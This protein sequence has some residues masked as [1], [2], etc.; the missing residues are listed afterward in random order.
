MAIDLRRGL[1][2]LLI[3]AVCAA[4]GSEGGA[5]APPAGPAVGVIKIDPAIPMTGDTIRL[6]VTLTGDAVRAEIKWTI[7][8]TEVQT[9]ECDGCEKP[10][11]LNQT[12]TKGDTV[13]ASVT[14]YNAGGE[15]GSRVDR[16][17]TVRN[18]PPDVKLVSESLQGG[19]YRAKIEGSDPEGG[20]INLVLESGPPGLT[21]DDKGNVE[22]KIGPD[23][24]SGRYE[25][26][27][28]VEDDMAQK[29]YLNYEVGIKWQK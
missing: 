1:L 14:P 18:A 21:M 8:G 2:L 26:K 22:W 24:P 3:C 28:S 4:A 5:Q 16:Y 29:T 6:N 9:S 27:V 17:I 13:V 20:P 19:Y 11:E 15:A 23:T 12:V 25:V 7:N 10:V